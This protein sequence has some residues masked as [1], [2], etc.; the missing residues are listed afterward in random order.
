MRNWPVPAEGRHRGWPPGFFEGEANRRA[1]LVLSCLRGITPR[2]LHELGWREGSAAAARSTVAAGRGGSA[3]DAALVHELD[4]MRVRASV[5]ACRARYLTPAD[6]EYPPRL[7]DLEDPPIGIFVR[8]REL[9]GLEPRVAVVGARTCSPLGAEVASDL[10]RELASAGICVVSGAARGIDSASHR[11]ALAAGGPTIAVLGSGIDVAYPASSAGLIATVERE[12]AV[13]SEY[14]PGVPAEPHRFPARNRIVAGMS[15]AVVVVEGGPR[16]GSKI[17]ADHALDLGREVFAVPGPVTS[18]LSA[19]PLELIR[20]GA[21]MI[22]GADDLLDD[23]GY[24]PEARAAAI[25]ADVPERDRRVLD[26]LAGP[27]LPETVAETFGLSVGEAVAALMRLEIRGLVR[28]VGGRY[29]ARLAPRD[30]D[31]SSA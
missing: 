9:D 4:A 8:G 27:S 25:I 10:G 5:A 11:G 24:D 19:A 28:S 23:L 14:P 29:E 30:T 17:T 1:A 6:P 12:G 15:R 31:R 3:A 26:A 7:E 20:E 18:P 2:R 16:S 21:A 22:R 13:V